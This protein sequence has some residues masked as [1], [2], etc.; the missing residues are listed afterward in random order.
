MFARPTVSVIIANYNHAEYLSDCLQSVLEQSYKHIEIVVV[1]DGSSDHSVEIM[2]N[3]RKKYPDVISPVLLAKI[4]GV[5]RARHS[6]IQKAKGEYISTLDADDYYADARKIEAEM[7]LIQEHKAKTEKNIIAFS[8]V[9]HETAAGQRIVQGNGQHV[10]QGNILTNIFGRSCMIPRDFTFLKSMYFE[11][12]GFD[13]ELALYEDFDLKIRLA[14][15]YEFYYTG[16]G[17]TVYRRHGKGLSSAPFSLHARCLSN[18][19]D[20]NCGLLAADQKDKI[21]KQLDLFMDAMNRATGK[22]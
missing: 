14:A 18:I 3:F 22:Y 17:G 5:A 20:K 16:V 2:E 13:F 15:R 12:G 10:F 21:K 19:F 11:T 4:N 8:N 1:D 7:E 6:G 9:I